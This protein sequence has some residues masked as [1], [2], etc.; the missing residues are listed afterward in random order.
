[1]KG[2]VVSLDT[3][4]AWGFHDL[5]DPPGDRVA[6]GPPACRWLLETLA[7][8][9]VPC[10]WAV[11]G[12]L[13]RS[14]CDGVHA[15]HPAPAGWFD[16]DPGSD[17][18]AAPEWYDPDLVAAIADS[19]VGH[20]VGSHTFSHLRFGDDATTPAMARAELA[21][22]VEAAADRGLALDSLVFPRNSVGHLDV[23][24]DCG[25]LAYRG[26][27]P[28]RWFDGS[29]LRPVGKA[30]SF[31]V[32]RD[33]PPIVT[34]AVDEHGLV[35]VPASLDLYCFEGT[36][37]RLAGVVAEDPVVRQVRLGLAELRRRE[38]GLL[39]LW[40]HPN[41]LR[42]EAEYRRFERV[43]ELIDRYRTDYDL[44]V[45]TMREVARAVR[46]DAAAVSS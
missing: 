15:D 7:E 1:M 40:C 31:V 19:P 45:R 27:R 29:P 28:N 26:R 43:L 24:A 8:Y 6:A 4:L 42:G 25:F 16:R 33:P 17:A 34:P 35:N 38:S 22:S 39:H 23:L 36:A 46:D 37:R 5:A 32:G 13:F 14:A 30:A 9:E 12:H 20:E 44:P 3:E 11:V 41:D 18:A 2:V 21:R 10:T